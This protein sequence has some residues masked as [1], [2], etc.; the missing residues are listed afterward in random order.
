VKAD[1]DSIEQARALLSGT[2]VIDALGGNLVSPEPP[3]TAAGSIIDRLRALG[4]NA[5]TVTMAAHN[6]SFDSFLRHVYDYTSLFTDDPNVVP[7]RSVADIA[8]AR[9]SGKLGVIY[10]AQTGAHVGERPW[11][12]SIAH[13]LGLRMSALAYNERNAL[14]GGCLEPHDGGLSSFGRQAVQEMNR[15]GILIDISHTGWRTSR[16]AIDYSAM[17]VVATHSNAHAL[18]PSPRN[19]PDDLI[20]AVAGSGGVV[21]LSPFSAMCW[22]EHGRRPTVED[23]LDHMEYVI[24]RIGADRVGIGTD[25]YESYTKIGWE[26][27]TKRSYPT[28]FFW[29]TRYS[30]DFDRPEGIETV[31][32]GLL[33]RGYG[34]ADVAGI[35]GGNWLRVFGSVWNPGSGVDLPARGW[36]GSPGG[37]L[38]GARPSQPVHE[39]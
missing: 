21:G 15:L 33:R 8:A 7:I 35:L 24:G 25:I 2:V 4:V 23:Y 9:E 3:R 16:D 38:G 19:L 11:L 29:E 27:G 36:L 18:T 34:E 1:Q 13:D 30:E 5:M 32:A 17:P 6:D 37:V 14:G 12:W 39:A 26:N 31:V 22:R 20:D 28:E 10:C